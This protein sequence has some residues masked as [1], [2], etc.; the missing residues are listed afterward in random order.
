M[1]RFAS[2][3]SSS[4][5]RARKW[6]GRRGTQCISGGLADQLADAQLWP[7]RKFDPSQ[8]A[9][10][11]DLRLVGESRVAG[12]PAVVLAVTPRDQH[13]YG[14]ELH[15]DRETGL[16]LKSLLLNEKAVARALPVHPVEYRRGTCRRPV[17][18]GRRMPGRRPGQ[19]R[20][21]EP[22]LALGVAAARFHP[23]PQFHAS[24]SGHPDPVACLTYGDGLA[25]FSVFIEPLHGA[26]VGDARS[27]LG[28]TVVVSKRLQTDDGGQMV[29][30]VGEVPLGTAERV[31]LSIRPG[32]PPRNDRGA[33]ASG[34]DR[35]GSGMGRDRAPQYLLV[36]LGQCRLRPGL[37]QRLGVGAGRARVR[38]LSDL[39]LR[40]GDAVVLGIHED[41]LLRASVL[42]YLFP[43]LGFSWQHCWRPGRALSNL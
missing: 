11:Y 8:L 12:R 17:A 39:S 16:P 19:G 28:P 23:D 27:Q 20:R 6:S 26:M 1:V 25:R 3:C 7:V 5:A 35:A 31:A 36:L 2:A 10:W 9:S 22:W 34:G 4:T 32:P 40:V 33:G 13:R 43:L 15:L 14:F 42:F 21:R 18:G 29:T 37:M 30:V 38:A 41:L 24:Q